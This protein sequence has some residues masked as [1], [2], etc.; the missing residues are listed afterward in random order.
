MKPYLT[1]NY[2]NAS[3]SHAPGQKARSVLEESRTTVASLMGAEAE[4][5]I[6]TGSATES[7]NLVTKGHAFHTGRKKTHLA[8]STV[9]HE[10]VL[11]SA[12]WL[13]TRGYRVTFLPVDQYGILELGKLE[14]TLK[15]GVSLV[16]VIHGNNEI[17][18][19]NPLKEIGKICH[20]YGALFHSD[21]AQ[22]FGKIPTNVN[23]LN[24]DLMTVNAHKTYGPK[25]V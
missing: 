10:C 22:S 15:K 11:N 6:F 5:L 9:E 8:V 18:T 20:Q 25:G 12:K 1:E 13:K 7:N 4:E 23:D 17:G 3:S 16:S 21:A 14:E 19:V 24:V 2:G